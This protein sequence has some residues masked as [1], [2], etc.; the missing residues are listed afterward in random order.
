MFFFMVS[1]GLIVLAG[2]GLSTIIS[3]GEEK[4]K[5]SRAIGIVTLLLFLLALLVTIFGDTFLGM[6]RNTAG[7][8]I[9]ASYGASD[10]A[11]RM[12]LLE[13]NFPHMQIRLWIAS[14]ISLVLFAAVHYFVNEKMTKRQLILG[15]I[16]VTLIDQWVFDRQYL[17]SS[18][19]HD[20][21]F[22]RDDIVS[23][24]RSDPDEYES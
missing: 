10:K 17:K 14:L 8:A 23:F 4:R 12:G 15:L 21:Y 7:P 20:R 22:A 6:I 13:R 3:D 11:R 2:I 9:E 16:L 18:P 1:F 5:M 24:L 19:A